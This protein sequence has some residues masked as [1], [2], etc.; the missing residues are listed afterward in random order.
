MLLKIHSASVLGIQ[1]QIIDIEVD[2][3]IRHGP[4]YNVVGLPDPAIKESGERVRAAIRNCG[5]Q[6][7]ETCHL[8]VNLAPADLKKEGSCYDLPIALAIL[9]LGGDLQP[10]AVRD[11]LVLGELSLDGRVRPIRGALPVALNAEKKNFRR[12]LLPSDNALEAAVVDGVDVYPA[13]TLPQVLQLLNGGC[14][15]YT[16]TKVDREELLRGQVQG[17]PNFADVK[18]Q[19]GAKRALEVATAGGHNILMLRTISPLL[20]PRQRRLFL[21][22]QQRHQ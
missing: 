9:G 21:R 16:P 4:K 18:G 6:F 8:T 19:A 5:Y 1:A 15:Q 11:W 3:S 22:A 14:E 17:L 13:V 2:I 12:L 20:R 10:Q 7:P